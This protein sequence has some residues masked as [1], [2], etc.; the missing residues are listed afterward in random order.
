MYVSIIGTC[1]AVRSTDRNRLTKPIFQLMVEKAKSVLFETWIQNWDLY[2]VEKNPIIL[3]SGGA[4]WADH[5]TVQVFLDWIKEQ[6][7]VKLEIHVPH[8]VNTETV[9][10][11]EGS[12]NGFSNPGKSANQ[13]FA[14][15]SSQMGRNMIQDFIT[16][17]T[18]PQCTIYTH[19][20]GFKHRDRV[21]AKKSDRMLALTWGDSTSEPKEGSG[22]AFTW[23]CFNPSEKSYKIHIPLST[24]ETTLIKQQE[25]Q[26]QKSAL[27]RFFQM[28]KEQP[29][30]LVSGIK[31]VRTEEEEKEEV[32]HP[33]QDKECPESKRQNVQTVPERER[34]K[35][36]ITYTSQ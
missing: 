15:F 8:T 32:N 14:Y 3:I 30:K 5:V 13:S 22:T 10:F 35:E 28:H 6:K 27:T 21:V 34:G 18:I 36:N 23:S 17:Q 31:R 11:V 2:S 26:Q 7:P 20:T 24:L 33:N 1:G 4:A 29:F 12:R 9:Q 19:Y 16:L 25:D